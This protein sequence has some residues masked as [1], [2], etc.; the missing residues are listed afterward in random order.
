[1]V[2]PYLVPG[3]VLV[4]VMEVNL[5][6][7]SLIVLTASWYKIQNKYFGLVAQK[8]VDWCYCI[9]DHFARYFS[10]LHGT[11]FTG[12]KMGS[13]KTVNDCT[14]ACHWAL[15]VFGC[16]FALLCWLLWLMVLVA[17]LN[18]CWLI[19]MVVGSCCS[20]CFFVAVKVVSCCG[21]SHSALAVAA[22]WE[23]TR[24]K[25]WHWWQW[26]CTGMTCSAASLLLLLLSSS[27]GGVHVV[28]H[29]RHHC[30]LLLL[31]L[32]TMMLIQ[33]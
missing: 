3:T 12:C 29:C 6:A 2:R 33:F 21:H 17:S 27:T 20:S 1:M 10:F 11:R 16:W 31:L 7:S 30:C 14:L 4:L 24:S 32:M 18:H 26:Q 9:V 13:K 25:R 8:Q 19:V 5:H 28:L 22:G 23:T 15:L